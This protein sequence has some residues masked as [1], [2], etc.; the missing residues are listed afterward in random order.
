MG[1]L[2]RY[3]VDGIF[4]S[5]YS[6]IEFGIFVGRS[7][8]QVYG[9]IDFGH[10]GRNVG[11]GDSTVVVGL[12]CLGIELVGIGGNILVG[13]VVLDAVQVVQRSH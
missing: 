7:I 2:T 5:A 4:E 12:Q 10:L 13:L 8:H 6:S 11:I 9:L 3:V 1:G